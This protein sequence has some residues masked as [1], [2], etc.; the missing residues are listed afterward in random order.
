MNIIVNLAFTVFMGGAILF[1]FWA[2]AEGVIENYKEN[3]TGEAA[4]QMFGLGYGLTVGFLL[5][6]KFL[7]SGGSEEL[8]RKDFSLDDVVLAMFLSTVVVL[9]GTRYTIRLLY[10]Q[11]KFS[12]WCSLSDLGPKRQFRWCVC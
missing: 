6:L 1:Y 11:A 3:T 8:F 9:S 7:Q 12:W 4:S 10:P 2:S 5:L